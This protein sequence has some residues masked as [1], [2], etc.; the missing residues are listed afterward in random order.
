MRKQVEWHRTKSQSSHEY[1]EWSVDNDDEYSI[2]VCVCVC[3]VWETDKK[4]CIPNHKLTRPIDS[5]S[6]FICVV[7]ICLLWGFFFW[8]IQK[9]IAMVVAKS[10]KWYS[11]Y[12]IAFCNHMAL[13]MH[14]YT[15]NNTIILISLMCRRVAKIINVPIRLRYKFSRTLTH[16]FHNEIVNEKPQL[17]LC[18][19]M[20]VW[21]CVYVFFFFNFRTWRFIV[22]TN[23]NAL[24][25]EINYF[26]PVV[27]LWLFFCLFLFE[28]SAFGQ[29]FICVNHRMRMNWTFK[30]HDDWKMC[31]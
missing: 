2:Y 14:I 22:C 27:I 18:V 21:A 11:F 17:H 15:N 4:E 3:R 30:P 8:P 19:L 28:T 13:I 20:W 24:F 9:Y 12:R 1:Y 23:F 10:L 7:H 31:T 6:N 29:Q 16:M 25:W 5:R 26:K